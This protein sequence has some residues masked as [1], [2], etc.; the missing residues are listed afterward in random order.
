MINEE[1]D[2][3]KMGKEALALV[4]RTKMWQDSLMPQGGSVVYE[5]PVAEGAFLR[6]SEEDSAE[7]WKEIMLHPI[8]L[9]AFIMA[10][11]D[12]KNV[13]VAVLEFFQTKYKVLTNEE[14]L[15]QS[16]YLLLSDDEI[17]DQ[18]RTMKNDGATGYHANLLTVISMRMI[19]ALEHLFESIE[20]KFESERKKNNNRIE[21]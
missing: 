12:A 2:G 17:M 13:V 4:M 20:K 11:M 8:T 15:E 6:M 7:R 18:F 21:E 3:A 10:Q 9:S 16:L 5:H 1:E 14:V 19:E